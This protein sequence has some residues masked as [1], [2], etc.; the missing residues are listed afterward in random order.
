MN[1]RTT[2]ARPLALV[3]SIAR[4]FSLYGRLEPLA[5]DK[6]FARFDLELCDPFDRRLIARAQA[7]ARQHRGN[8]TG[9]E[10]RL[11]T[12]TFPQATPWRRSSYIRL[13]VSLFEALSRAGSDR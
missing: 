9:P 11:F 4:E 5:P 7:F 6:G 10:H 2:H 3:L 13:A 1:A 12:C 8:V